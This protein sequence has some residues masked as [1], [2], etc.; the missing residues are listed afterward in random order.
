MKYQIERIAKKCVCCGSNDLNKL[1]AI[2]MP[3]VADR[4]LG[5]KP[6][7]IDKSW[8]LNSIKEGMAYSICNT[9]YCTN[10]DF[11]FLDVRFSESELNNLYEDY[12]GTHYSLLRENYEPGYLKKNN[13]LING[14]DYIV[15]IED[16]LKPYIKLPVSILDWGGDTGKNTPFK[17]KNK[18]FH[19]F[20]ISSKLPI[21][22]AKFV[23]KETIFNTFYDVI[24]CSNVLEHVPFPSDLILDIR[25][26][27]NKE[28]V[29][30]I[31][32]PLE[33]IIRTSIDLAKT[34]SLKKHWH[35]HINFF[36]ED[37]LVTLLNRSGLEIIELKKEERIFGEASSSYMFQIACRLVC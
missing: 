32:V 4:A 8:G 26:A 33:E 14:I 29:L 9:L 35:E 19:V 17:E 36:S 5:Y 28:T 6:V 24:I 23:D 15:K 22:G 10:C 37:S 21:N 30:Y 34:F 7:Q 13:V 2:I 3:F 12:R 16:F 20:D 31:E 25:K 1:P 11:L 27:M 18:N